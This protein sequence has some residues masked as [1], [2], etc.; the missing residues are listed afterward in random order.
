MPSSRKKPKPKTRYQRF[1]EKLRREKRDGKGRPLVLSEGDSWFAFPKELRPSTMD[2]LDRKLDLILMRLE[3][4][5][6]ELSAMLSGKQRRRLQY[7]LGKWDFNLLLFSGGGN[8]IVGDRLFPLL[9]TVSSNDPWESV[10]NKEAMHAAFTLIEFYYRDL[11][12][13]GTIYALNATSLPIAMT[14]RF[15]TLTAK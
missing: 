14:T 11:F 2:I 8:D 6:D 3:T 4:N 12:K 9:N 7:Y 15:P 5:G 10:I 13:S 1:L